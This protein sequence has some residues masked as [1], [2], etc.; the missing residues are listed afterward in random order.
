M[1]LGKGV[2][3]K[4]KNMKKFFGK[5]STQ[6]V[7]MLLPILIGF[8]TFTYFPLLYIVR[9][10]IT[11]SNGFIANFVGLDNFVRAFTRDPAF[12][13]AVNN[14]LIL[15]FGKLAVEIPLALF[16]A[17][18]L[19]KKIKFSNLYR[20][21]LFLP[22]I[23]STA[24]VGI[25]FTL[26]FAAFR[27]VVNTILMDI[28]LITIPIDWFATRWRALFVLGSASVW[29]FTGIN[30]VFFLMA[31]QGIPKDVYEAAD[32]DGAVGF[33]RFIFI[34]LPMIGPVFR[35]ILLNAIIGSIQVT[36]LVLAGTNGAPFGQ[37][38][39]I[40]TH[41]F[42]FFFAQDGRRMEVGYA[43]ALAVITAFILGIITVIYLRVTKK[44]DANA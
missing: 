24:I 42:K 17:V 1:I 2:A 41:I 31:L 11:D 35:V 20:V 10:S 7:L 43:S 18:L 19:N 30:V 8:F 21:T 23:I 36:D 34:T 9:F 28:G 15:T 13:V 33:R 6:A 16:L 29:T 27:G 44:L 3:P 26:M 5:D 22:S 39:V 4:E 12:W 37:T 32:L 38:E 14:T 25:I 40:M